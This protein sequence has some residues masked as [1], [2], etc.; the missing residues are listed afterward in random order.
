MT[1]NF[2]IITNFDVTNINSFFGQPKRITLDIINIEITFIYIL[3]ICI[4]N[5]LM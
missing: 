5:L 2:N 1:F 3:T 4:N